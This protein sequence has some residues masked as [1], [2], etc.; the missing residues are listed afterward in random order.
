[1]DNR[2]F[3]RFWI[4]ITAAFVLAA[5][6][7]GAW[8]ISLKIT[9]TD[10][11]EKYNQQQ[12]FLVTGIAGGIEGL[13]DDLAASLGSLAM[14]PEIQYFDEA[15]TRQELGRKLGELSPQGIIDIGILDA[16][17]VA[18][19]FAV[20]KEVEGIDYSWRSFY[21]LARDFSTSNESLNLIIE[22]QTLDQGE[23][24]FRIIIPF[25]ETALDVNHQD[26]DGDFAG[27][28]LGNLTLNT[29]I[30]RYVS[31][32]KPPGNGNIFL[33]NSDFDIIWSSDDAL[34]HANI[35]AK[36]QAGL[37][38]IVEQIVTWTY[39]N[40]HSNAYTFIHPS[41][42]NPGELIAYA[43]VR[44]GLEMLAV[45]VKTPAGVARQ[46]SISTFQSQQFVFILSV[47]TILLGVLLGV[48]VLR[49]ETRRRFQMEEVLRKSEMEQAILAERNRLA[50]DLH[51]S[52]TQGLYGIVLHAGAAVGQI[53]SGEINKAATYL[54][55]IKEAG[56]EGLAEMRLLIYELR[57]PILVE[58]GLVAALESRLYAVEKRAGLSVKLK[59][60]IDT[61][62]PLEV[63]ESLYRVTQEALNN[64][65]KY[66]QA[67]HVLVSLGQKGKIVTL[68]ITDDGC[69]FDINSARRGG[70]MGL[71]NMETRA[72]KIGGRMEIESNPGSGTIILIE[73]NV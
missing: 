19:I 9:E 1:M 3:T 40:A 58:E 32:F 35:L 52:V 60:E 13:F 39:D 25:Y 55:E 48:F 16:N 31:P 67:Q 50:S 34:N 37:T 2:G 72:Q 27:V 29:L 71:L 53:T 64:A 4:I 68:K 61:R 36:D 20:Q 8:F 24:G 44:I 62:L 42:G 23:M 30:E 45:V 63:E 59:S 70:G 56:K 54:E 18:R 28:I 57:P 51:D 33:V 38:S 26:P 6:F 73:V 22:L 65:L 21:K 69:G 5:L 12:L 43:P 11:L 14:L 7:L 41:G 10:V 49:R 66:A 46:T 15:S 47:S 17:G